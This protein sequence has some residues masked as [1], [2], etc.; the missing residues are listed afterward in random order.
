MSPAGSPQWP[1]KVGFPSTELHIPGR[2]TRLTE[3]DPQVC[4]PESSL[5]E[6]WWPQRPF[7]PQGKLEPGLFSTLDVGAE[8]PT[9]E[10]RRSRA[11]THASRREAWGTGERLRRGLRG[12]DFDAGGGEM[13]AEEPF[14]ADVVAVEQ[15]R[16]K[17]PAARGVQGLLGEVFARAG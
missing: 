13:K 9:P 15:G 6:P 7:V 1:R 17:F 10:R 16:V 3:V 14:A 11:K 4:F 12:D 2:I 8:A 5:T